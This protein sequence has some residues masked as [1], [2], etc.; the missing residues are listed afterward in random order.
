M[1]A[2][3][4]TSSS[5]GKIFK[6]F[7]DKLSWT[8]RW[9]LWYLGYGASQALIKVFAASWGSAVVKTNAKWTG[10]ILK[11]SFWFFPAT[12]KNSKFWMSNGWKNSWGFWTLSPWSSNREIGVL[13]QVPVCPTWFNNDSWMTWDTCFTLLFAGVFQNSAWNNLIITF[14]FF[15]SYPSKPLIPSISQLFGP[16]KHLEFT[17][18]LGVWQNRADPNHTLAPCTCRRG[19]RQERCP[20]WQR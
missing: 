12:V 3:L 6:G 7:W 19:R 2:L 9:P 5:K 17:P 18:L 20:G 13:L 11:H 4:A 10:K 14:F 16:Q 1:T 8:S 15:G